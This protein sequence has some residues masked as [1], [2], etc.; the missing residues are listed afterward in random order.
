MSAPTIVRTKVEKLLKQRFQNVRAAIE[1]RRDAF[2]QSLKERIGRQMDLP[3]L[4]AK[5]DAVDKVCGETRD[6]VY[7]AEQE[8]EKRCK[9]AV[10]SVKQSV[11]RLLVRLADDEAAA[12]ERL[13]TDDM[14]GD[15]KTLVESVPK[16]E[17]LLNGR[18]KP[19]KDLSVAESK[20]AEN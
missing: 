14:P 13:W 7:D 10:R 16:A 17:E 15:M 8:L 18:L 12:I 11:Q 5:R 1:A 9:E 3:R 20:A 4:H 6:A 2:E 19:L